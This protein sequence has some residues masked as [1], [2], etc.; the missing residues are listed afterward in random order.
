MMLSINHLEDSRISLSSKYKLELGIHIFVSHF[1]GLDE[2][3]IQ[4]DCSLEVLVAG[5]TVETVGSTCRFEVGFIRTKGILLA[6][7]DVDE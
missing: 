7:S 5:K 2:T 6:E 3:V 1:T 4:G